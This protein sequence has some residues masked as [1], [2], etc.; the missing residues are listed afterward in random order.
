MTQVDSSAAE[1]EKLL[2]PCAAWAAAVAQLNQEDR[3]RFALLDT[4]RKD[5]RLILTRCPSSCE[6][7]EE[8][9]HEEALEDHCEWEGNRVARRDAGDIKLG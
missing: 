4:V 3:E 5:M 8:R 9:V 2:L 1:N 7:K 6:R